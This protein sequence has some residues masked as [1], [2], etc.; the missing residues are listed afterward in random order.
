MDL[1]HEHY[2]LYSTHRVSASFARIGNRTA[3]NKKTLNFNLQ[4]EPLSSD[5][6]EAE[7]KNTYWQNFETTDKYDWNVKTQNRIQEQDHTR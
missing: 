6:A 2:P 3:N 4:A 1:N 5:Q 7:E